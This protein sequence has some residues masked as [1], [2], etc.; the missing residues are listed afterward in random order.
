MVVVTLAVTRAHQ[1]A[2]RPFLFAEVFASN[3]GGT[4]TLIGD[5]PNIL[6]GSQVGLDF[7]AFLANVAP[8]A[9]V[10]MAVQAVLVHLVWGRSLR[11]SPES[12]VL[13]MGMHAPGMVT[14]WVLLRRSVVVMGAV[15][16]AF[17]FAGPLRLQPATIAVAGAAA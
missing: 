16:A 3:V 14:D 8:V 11:A 4:A 15:L 13:V 10:V 5:P 17:V 7:N 6:I 2:P 9:V 1:V 12:R